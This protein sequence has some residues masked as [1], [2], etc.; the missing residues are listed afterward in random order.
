MKNPNIGLIGVGALGSRHLQALALSDRIL[1]IFVMDPSEASLKKAEELFYQMSNASKHQILFTTRMDQMAK[2]FDVVI[3]ATNSNVRRQVIEQLITC[4]KV[5]FL[6]I[7]KVLFQRLEDYEI[8]SEA[9]KKNNIRAWVNCTRRLFDFYQNL[10]DRL[11][12][13]TS[14]EISI[15]G[16]KWGLGCNAIHFLDLIAYLGGSDNQ[17]LDVSGLDKQYIKSKR[18]GFLEITGTISGR[19]GRCNNYS[20]T[21]YLNNNCPISISISSDI[22]KCIIN[23][24][25]K[26]AIVAE[27]S[28]NWVWKEESFQIPYQSQLTHL[29]VQD[30][31]DTG[32]CMLTEYEVSKQFHSKLQEPLIQYFEKL[33]VEGKICPIT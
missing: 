13:A 32:N 11:L 6:I 17:K 3:I 28:N 24:S 20:I 7:E 21:S 29:V 27:A 19:I 12:E 30:I 31:L 22:L 1:N 2:K 15:S 8:V 18:R 5:K 26:K 16:S 23:E 14:F 25:E 4:C 10:K 33:G 9:L